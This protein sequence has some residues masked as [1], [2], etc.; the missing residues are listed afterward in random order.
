M[1]A[2]SGRSAHT[3]VSLQRNN[4]GGS[5]SLELL[6]P[7]LCSLWWPGICGP[8]LLS[9]SVESITKKKWGE[10]EREEKAHNKLIDGEPNLLVFSEV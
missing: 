6:F 5:S 9:K 2:Q 7:L 4:E 10:G 1:N 3:S 8:W